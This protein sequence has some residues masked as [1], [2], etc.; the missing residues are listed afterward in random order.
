MPA[1]R[2]APRR[3]RLPRFSLPG[4]ELARFRRAVITR[5]ALLTVVVVPLI[6]GGLYLSA[7]HDPV[8]ELGDLRAAVVD[9]DR[10]AAVTG[11]DGAP[12][13]LDAGADLVQSLTGPDA[14]AGF[15]WEEASEE[16]ARRGLEDGTY[17]AVL[18]VPEGFSAALA[19]AGGDDPQRAR[20]SVTTDDAE[21]YILGQV[22]NTVTTSIRTRV[23]S[24]AT[25]DYLEDVYVAFTSVHDSLGR[26][27]DGAD[28]LTTGAQRA[29][30]GARQLVVGLGDL[31]TGA[32]R[33]ADGTGTL[34]SGAADL[35][36]GTAQ[37]A[38]GADGAASG[39][40]SLSAG[41][42]QL[43]GA[44]GAL[45]ARTSQ[46]ADGARAVST[47][48]AQVAA[49]TGQLAQVADRLDEL[50]ASAGDLGPALDG[51]LERARAL[52][53]ANPGDAQLAAAVQRLEQVRAA[54]AQQ[55][56]AAAAQRVGAQVGA[57]AE[58]A[59]Q[60]STGAASVATGARRLADAAGQ[61]GGGVAGAA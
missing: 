61:G 17:A 14:A 55:D 26:A 19:S 16:E 54:L 58:G 40:A 39:A 60:V 30:D 36:G 38:A 34:R 50:A 9:A 13:T 56:L 52:A 44:T 35:A 49:G 28:Q 5:L 46:L 11:A 33:L 21:N 25:Q 42:E 3:A 41:L 47:G 32:A 48:A 59:Q 37:L 1:P 43:R 24:S 29:D 22:A 12:R 57:L 51:L 23:S 27:A 31:G 4:L 7:N 8:G 2:T 20:L 6:Y 10:P 53:A 45:P 15:A 18:R